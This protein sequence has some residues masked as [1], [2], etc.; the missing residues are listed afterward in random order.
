MCS[1][2]VSFTYALHCI[3]MVLGYNFLHPL[4]FFLCVYM[5]FHSVVAKYSLTSIFCSK[6]TLGCF[7]TWFDCLGQTRVRLPPPCPHWSAFILFYLGLNRGSFA[8]SSQQL[9]T[10]FLSNGGKMHNIAFSALLYIYVFELFFL[11]TKL[12]YV[13]EL[14]S[15]LQMYNKCSK[16]RWR[17]TEMRSTALCLQRVSHA[18][19][20]SEQN[21]FLSN[22]MSLIVVHFHDLVRLHSHQQQTV[23][24]FTWTNPRPSFLRELWYSSRVR[25]RGQ[26]TVFTSSKR[27]ELWRQTNPDAQQKC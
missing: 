23:P 9:F 18:R 17:W 1:D 22:N 5:A 25:T 8:S 26:M 10:P 3:Y 2:I 16:V 15:F 7:H 19:Q 12:R 4:L 13:T 24:E 21:T 11:F 6:S 27:T 14:K 20:E